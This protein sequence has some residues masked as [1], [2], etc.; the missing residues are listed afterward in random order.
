MSAIPSRDRRSERAEATRREILDAAWAL[1][2]EEGLASLT[3][4]DLGARVGMKAQSLYGY[5]ASKHDIYDA[6]FATGA[7]QFVD[8]EP[9]DQ[10]N[11]DAV[12][13]VRCFVHSFVRFCAAD[14]ARYQ[15]LFQRPIPGFEPSAASYAIA[16]STLARVG[17]QLAGLG[18]TDPRALDLLTAL[19]A[20]LASQQLANDPGGD[21]WIRLID[22]AVEMYVT[23]MTASN[24]TG[25]SAR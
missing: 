10:L 19:S 12:H 16:E 21:R 3:M 17:E 4:R 7:Q 14:L 11:G 22:D 24:S 2:R 9:W 23:Y 5:F 13:D 25:T 15:L 8:A 1:V 6:M 20:G 18:I